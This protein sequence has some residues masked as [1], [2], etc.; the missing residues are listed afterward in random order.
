MSYIYCV[1]N[2]VTNEKY[3]GATRFTIDK[4][5][6]EHLSE[7][8]KDRAKN[9]PLYSAINTYGDSSFEISILEECDEEVAFDREVYWIKTLGTFIDGYNMTFGGAGKRYVDYDRIVRVYYQ[10]NNVDETAKKL[11][12]CKDVV[13]D[14]LKMNGIKPQNVQDVMKFKHG[15]SVIMYSETN[16]YIMRFN[17]LHEASLYLIANGN[18][19]SESIKSTNARSISMHIRDVCLGKRKTAYGYIWRFTA[20]VM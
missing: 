12:Y 16:E 5:W 4:R 19:K 11:G 8:K 2:I 13:Y 7:A 3:V 15:I 17:S 9:R 14:A 18:G 1:R 20:D 10:T 6:H